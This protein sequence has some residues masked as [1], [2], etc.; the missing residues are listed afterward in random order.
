MEIPIRIESSS[1]SS[2]SSSNYYDFDEK[3][4][5]DLKAIV[6]FAQLKQAPMSDFIIVIGL[7]YKLLSKLDSLYYFL[8]LF[9]I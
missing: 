6:E 5:K 1:S 3:R 8:L 2:S 4:E 9:R 7:E